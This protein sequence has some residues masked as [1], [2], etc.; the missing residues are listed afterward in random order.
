VVNGAVVS[1][2]VLG[3]VV[4]QFVA[5]R[6]PVEVVAIGSALVLWAT[7]VIDIDQ[8][9]AGFGD[10][11]VILIVALF[12]VSE[13]LD[14]TGVRLP[15]RRGRHRH[16][17]VRRP[18]GVRARPR[19]GRGADRRRRARRRHQVRRR[20]RAGARGG[21]RPRRGGA[22]PDQPGYGVAEVVVPPRSRLVG[23]VTAPGRV[24]P[25]GPL[26]VLAVQRQGRNRARSALQV[27]DV[28]L[29]E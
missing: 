26:V 27:G 18:T 3:L 10:P 8:A 4:V 2:V 22:R 15:G 20:P 29:L 21:A 6:L 13:G 23:E 5:N 16:R 28:L 19:R 14:A 1:L 7:G 17:H 25:G 9:V 11:T 24:V 12:V